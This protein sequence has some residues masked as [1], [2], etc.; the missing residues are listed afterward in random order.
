MD[1]VVARK[2]RKEKRVNFYSVNDLT[3]EAADMRAAARIAAARI[4]A[5][6]YG[7]AG[8]VSRVHPPVADCKDGKATFHAFVGRAVD[9]VAGVT[10]GEE[11][12]IDVC[13]CQ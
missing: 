4:A 11:V 1:L 10:I 8:V 12:A 13:T 2:R 5:A 6:K 9:G 7:Q 3:V